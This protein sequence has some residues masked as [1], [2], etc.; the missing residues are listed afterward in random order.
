MRAATDALKR[1]GF[2]LDLAEAG[3]GADIGK[4]ARDNGIKNPDKILEDFTGYVGANRMKNPQT[5]PNEVLAAL[6]A[7]VPD[8]S[9]QLNPQDIED[10]GWIIDRYAPRSIQKSQPVAAAQFQ[11][12]RIR[13]RISSLNISILNTSSYSKLQIHLTIKVKLTWQKTFCI[14]HLH[15]C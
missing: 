8:N 7:G 9:D 10:L 3:E 14:I 13:I 2:L 11:S 1:N 15:L 4:I 5:Y 12:N 6:N